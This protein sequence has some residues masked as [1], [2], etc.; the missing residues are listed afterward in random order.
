MLRL[1]DDA[2]PCGCMCHLLD[3]QSVESMGG[4]PNGCLC[5]VDEDNEPLV[6]PGAE[7][8]RYDSGGESAGYRQSMHDAGRGHLLG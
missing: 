4:C 5:W 3:T 6:E 2:P 1:K 8:T 7:E